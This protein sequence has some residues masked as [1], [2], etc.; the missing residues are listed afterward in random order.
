L[1]LKD[2]EEQDKEENKYAAFLLNSQSDN[3]G[4]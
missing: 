1:D 2:P 3:C 4:G